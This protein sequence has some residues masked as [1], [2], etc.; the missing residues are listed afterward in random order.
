MG[1]DHY[2]SNSP[3]SPS[4]RRLL[5]VQLRGR[6]WRFTTDRGVFSG[7]R[8][9]PGSRL[10]IE[11]MEIN[12][13]DR[14]LDVGAG[15]GPIGVVA[16][17]LAGPDGQATL[18][19]VNS[20]AAALAQENAS[21]NGVGNVTLVQTDD[22]ASLALPPQDVV[23][24][25]PPVRTGWKVVMPLLEAAASKL[26]PGGRLWLVGYKHLGVN[27]LGKHLASIL[28]PPQTVAKQGGYR[29]LVA[30]REEARD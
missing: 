5:T 23:V 15:Y 11:Q 12:P 13:G 9:D 10:L 18:L 19:E 30:T 27:S 20:R 1:N 3:H 17:F 25:N 8:I 6:E 7:D 29:V 22:L 2:Y 28:G 14:V 26:R 21:Q 4:E 24:T 16:G